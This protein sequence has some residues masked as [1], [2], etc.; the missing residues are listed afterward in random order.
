[1]KIEGYKT[2]VEASKIFHRKVRTI[3]QWISDKKLKA[4]K[5]NNFI[6]LIADEDVEKKVKEL[7]NS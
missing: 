4:T 6:W 5:F 2:I 7:K 3:R 1:M